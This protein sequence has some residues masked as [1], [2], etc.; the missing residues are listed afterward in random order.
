MIKTSDEHGVELFDIQTQTQVCRIKI[1]PRTSYLIPNTDEVCIQLRR[2]VSAYNIY[3]GEFV[4]KFYRLPNSHCRVLALS[5][6][7]LELAYFD[8][9]THD[10]IIA[11]IGTRTPLFTIPN[12]AFYDRVVYSPDG[13]YLAYSR[14]FSISIVD[15]AT[16]TELMTF[17]VG[18]V[19]RCPAFSSDST[20][21]SYSDTNRIQLVDVRTL[22]HLKTVDLGD[23]RI[24]HCVLSPD[25]T[26]MA[27]LSRMNDGVHISFV[28]VLT[29]EIRDYG[30]VRGCPLSMA[31]SLDNSLLAVTGVGLID[32]ATL[33]VVGRIPDKYEAD[34]IEFVRPASILM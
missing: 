17:D 11:D 4:R 13:R 2:T 34:E 7:G 33:N 22:T 16:K 25:G 14:R 30:S 21:L 32:V 28:D 20:M 29:D 3:T 15:Y 8:P 19:P 10:M 12:S 9:E 23:D 26:T 31:F 6:D 27:L 1:K 24:Q 18:V 5:F